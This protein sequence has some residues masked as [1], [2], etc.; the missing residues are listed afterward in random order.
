MQLEE[1]K[2]GSRCMD[3]KRCADPPHKSSFAISLSLSRFMCLCSCNNSNKGDGSQKS[4]HINKTK[5]RNNHKKRRRNETKTHN[6]QIV[7]APFKTSDS[8]TMMC[9]CAHTIHSHPPEEKQTAQSQNS[10]ELKNSGTGSSDD[11]MVQKISF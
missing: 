9:L 1:T 6:S 10:S 11:K 2:N 4:T 8:K 5:Q 3:D 7:C